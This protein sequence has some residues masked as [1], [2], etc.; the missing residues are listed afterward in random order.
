MLGLALVRCVSHESGRGP[1]EY[2][3]SDAERSDAV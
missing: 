3:L 1:P 2:L